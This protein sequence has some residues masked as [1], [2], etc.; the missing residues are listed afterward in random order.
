M[1]IINYN[2]QN[3]LL[4]YAINT[5]KTFNFNQEKNSFFNLN[6]I[7][8][9]NSKSGLQK[10]KVIFIQKVYSLYGNWK[11]KENCLFYSENF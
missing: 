5:E 1:T 11:G 2:R 3:E 10:T 8:F 4:W 9:N 6:F 7:V